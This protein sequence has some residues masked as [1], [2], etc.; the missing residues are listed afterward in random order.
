VALAES[1]VV[2]NN[3]RVIQ[4]EREKERESERERE[5]GGE[6]ERPSYLARNA[7]RSLVAAI[8]DNRE[9]SERGA[10][11]ESKRDNPGGPSSRSSVN[12]STSARTVYIDVYGRFDLGR[13]E[14]SSVQRMIFNGNSFAVAG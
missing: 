13:V 3:R 6:G 7:R 8:I 2:V 9:P 4:K 12:F 1:F 11:D 5:G 14:L 10:S